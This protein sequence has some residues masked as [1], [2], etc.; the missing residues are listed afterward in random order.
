MDGEAGIELVSVDPLARALDERERGAAAG[1]R[2]R[3]TA[4]EPDTPRQ[5]RPG[6]PGRIA[7]EQHPVR[8][9]H[10]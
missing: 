3:A 10:E 6:S 1:R 9:A 5:G 8:E 2:R 4:R 7:P